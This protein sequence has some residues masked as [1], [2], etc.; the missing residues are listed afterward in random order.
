MNR[1]TLYLIMVITSIFIASCIPKPVN[2]PARPV[3]IY[4]QSMVDQNE[5][6][7]RRNSC[8]FWEAN[9]QQDMDA[10]SGV[11]ARV[12]NISCSVVSQTDGL[13]EVSCEGDIVATYGAEESRFPLN[14]R[15]YLSLNTDDIWQFCGHP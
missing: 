14:V 15:N 8:S 13:A 1:K 5:P 10:F 7:M 3:E 6:T 11:L 4:I 2:N 12:E 9:I